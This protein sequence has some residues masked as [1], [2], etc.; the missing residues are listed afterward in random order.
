MFPIG[1]K[2]KCAGY[3]EFGMYTYTGVVD[4]YHRGTDGKTH[5]Y[6]TSDRDNSSGLVWVQDVEAIE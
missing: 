4:G 5:Y 3:S 2:V 6:V 1:S